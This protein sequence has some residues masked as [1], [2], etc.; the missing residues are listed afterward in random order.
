[1]KLAPWM[2]ILLALPLLGGCGEHDRVV[3]VVVTE[4]FA[5]TGRLAAV[6]PKF[7]R[8][9]HLRVKTTVTNARAAVA[10][11]EAGAVDLI[12]APDDAGMKRLESEGI[13]R[14]IS[15]MM[16][17]KLLIVGP[18]DDPLGIA[19]S[20]WNSALKR[21]LGYRR[22]RLLFARRGEA[23]QYLET[24]LAR[25]GRRLEATSSGPATEA[26]ALLEADRD[27]RYALVHASAWKRLQN[28]CR[29]TPLLASPE[30]AGLLMLAAV[31]G[32]DGAL[33]LLDRLRADRS[34]R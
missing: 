20:D 5:A 6:V 34:E 28:R 33:R 1:M 16:K 15:P 17:D 18:M 25:R 7:E 19:E 21:L 26:G 11:A 9:E 30:D 22:P 10:L 27:Q 4:E 2:P 12:I 24:W 8:K 29:L 32:N 13:A 23:G 31:V 14:V 3:R